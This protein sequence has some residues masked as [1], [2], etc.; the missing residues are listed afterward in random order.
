[1]PSEVTFVEPNE[2]FA[3]ETMRVINYDR[4]AGKITP[5]EKRLEDCEG[6]ALA[7]HDL[8]LC[9][10]T[11]Y[12]LSDAEFEKLLSLVDAGSRLIVIF[13]D[14]KSIFSKLW[15][16][17]APNFYQNTQRHRDRL[18]NLDT[19]RFLVDKSMVS[20]EIGDPRSLRPDIS[21]LVISMLCYSDV[22]DM[23]HHQLEEVGLLISQAQRESVISCVSSVYD[24]RANR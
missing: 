8:I 22:E 24:I 5:I 6:S 18:E 23:P 7:G 4:F 15:Q 17:T 12:F 20:A 14:P 1:M 16:R 21:N 3:R 10:H 9:T 19:T 13:D 2:K 11:A